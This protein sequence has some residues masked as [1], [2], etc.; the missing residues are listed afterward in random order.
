MRGRTTS[1]VGQADCLHV[2]RKTGTSCRCPG[3][4]VKASGRSAPSLFRDL[5]AEAAPQETER[6]AVRLLRIPFLRAP[7]AERLAW[8]LVLSRCTTDPDQ[9]A[10]RRSARAG[11]DPKSCRTAP[12]G[13]IGSG[14]HRQFAKSHSA[15]A[16]R[17]TAHRC[18][19]STSAV[20]H[21]PVIPPAPS[22]P[23]TRTRHQIGNLAPL[24]SA[25][26]VPPHRTSPPDQPHQG[27]S[28]IL[29]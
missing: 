22:A 5:D 2:C 17:A 28:H 13:A 12:H 29:F 25:Q 14:A 24:G 8:A 27:N 9:S 16:A 19:A 7:A 10:P 11:A 20:H 18:T 3:G 21:L 6:M 15:R 1:W 23:R 26:F 4:S